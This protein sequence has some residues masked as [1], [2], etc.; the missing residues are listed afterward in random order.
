MKKLL[1]ALSL[2]LAV[3]VWAKGGKKKFMLTSPKVA[4]GK[5]IGEEQVFN[6]FG[7]SG[8]NVSP[9]LNWVNAPKETK[10]FVLTVYDPDAPTGSGWWHW[11]VFNIPGDKTSLPEGFGNDD[12]QDFGVQSRTDFGKEGYG[13][14]CPPKGDKPHKYIFKLCALKTESL[15][16]EED[17]PAAMVGFYTNANKIE[18]T[19]FAAKYGR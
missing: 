10:S 19:E 8:K 9:E 13:G 1:L 15:P 6:G 7:C 4:H 2:I 16:L 14:P 17:S 11:V 12:D 18:C 5:M 3:A